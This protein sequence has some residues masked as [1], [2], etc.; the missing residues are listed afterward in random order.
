VL[1]L[2]I[3]LILL[4]AWCII[5]SC[6]YLDLLSSLWTARGHFILP[7]QYRLPCTMQCTRLLWQAAN[8]H[9]VE[10]NSACKPALCFRCGNTFFSPFWKNAGLVSL[11]LALPLLAFPPACGL[12]SGYC[13]GDAAPESL[14]RNYRNFFQSLLQA[15][16]G[17]LFRPLPLWM[18]QVYCYQ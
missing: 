2:S 16:T 12:S 5:D 3:Y 8:L 1:P 4:G 17:F 13:E 6:P 18:I 9:P 7:V 10:R 11:F 15:L 14:C